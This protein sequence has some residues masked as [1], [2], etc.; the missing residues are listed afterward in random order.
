MPVNATAGQLGLNLG[1]GRQN[2]VE[3]RARELMEQGLGRQEALQQARVELSGRSLGLPLGAEGAAVDLEGLRTGE[4]AAGDTE[5]EDFVFG[6]EFPALSRDL[7]R[8][9][10]EVPSP[11]TYDDD[12]SL[13]GEDGVPTEA[14]A[15]PGGG[16]TGGITL[17]PEPEVGGRPETVAR[18]LEV[19]GG[20]G[21]GIG[22][23]RSIGKA[24][25][26]TAQ[27]Q[28]LSNLV[29]TLRGSATAGVAREEPRGGLLETLGEGIG[30]GAKSFREGRKLGRD[31][32]NVAARQGFKDKISLGELEAKLDGDTPGAILSDT[33]RRN[34]FIQQ[35]AQFAGRGLSKE[36]ALT[37]L[38][39]SSG[40]LRHIAEN[41][42]ARESFEFSMQTGFDQENERLE[43]L[44]FRRTANTL[45]MSADVRADTQLDMAITGGKIAQDRFLLEK[46]RAGRDVLEFEMSLEEFENKGVRQAGEAAR[47][48]AYLAIA[49]DKEGRAIDAEGR[50][51]DADRE[52]LVFD[53]REI[54][55]KELT[56]LVGVKE[57]GGKQ[58]IGP[59]Y[60]RMKASYLDWREKLEAGGKVDKASFQATMVNFFQRMIDPATVREGDVALLRAAEGWLR[61]TEAK[62]SA[63]V[64]GGFVTPDL[65]EGMMAQAIIMQGAQ[66]R[67]VQDEI[68]KAINVWNWAHGGV[69]REASTITAEDTAF[70]RENILGGREASFFDV[71]TDVGLAKAAREKVPGAI[72][73]MRL[74]PSLNR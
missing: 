47:A 73:A 12:S 22:E 70:L 29:N 60:A 3:R 23:S 55:R 48:D 33:D 51:V 68:D 53:R 62:L 36:E 49:Q 37:E 71:M 44:D 59:A 52:Q 32:R 19:L 7:P 2:A 39:K 58:G 14:P 27:R 40:F 26:L 50:A 6:K 69:G 1:L 56:T 34:L 54:I 45:A 61:E 57:F 35:G 72:T 4:V 17:P 9:G 15:A 13:A 10:A 41:P 24:N 30:A 31:E 74:R 38:R 20:I 25:K 28:A 11:I 67:F 65:I 5:D 63:I 46:A 64:E 42:G 16:P 18:I 43:N 66:R 21:A 8:P